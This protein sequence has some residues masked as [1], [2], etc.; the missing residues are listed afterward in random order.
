MDSKTIFIV[1][2]A[3][4]GGLIANKIYIAIFQYLFTE[5][6]ESVLH[7][8]GLRGLKLRTSIAILLINLPGMVRGI[9]A[10]AFSEQELILT[11]I[12]ISS[13]FFALFILLRNLPKPSNKQL[14]K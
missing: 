2:F 6:Y 5:H 4:I 8:H 3:A 9:V 1:I 14:K 12:C 11:V 13:A 7:Q 10:P